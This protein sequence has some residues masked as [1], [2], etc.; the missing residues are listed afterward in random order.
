M[1]TIYLIANLNIYLVFTAQYNWIAAILAA[2]LNFSNSS[3][4]SGWHPVDYQSGPLKDSKSAKNNNVTI[5]LVQPPFHYKKS[6]ATIRSSSSRFQTHG[7]HGNLTLK[8][9]L[10]VCL[11]VR[12]HVDCMLS[13][14]ELCS[15]SWWKSG[16]IFWCV[17]VWEQTNL[18]YVDSLFIT[19]TRQNIPP[20]HPKV[21][22]LVKWA[23]VLRN[24]FFALRVLKSN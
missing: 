8:W 6:Q 4:L 19:L 1:Q 17:I 7:I 10:Y 5:F 2:I 22:V 18:G 12:A 9:T 23:L 13:A 14:H 3:R 24:L 20:P 11:C 15:V 21:N 16:A